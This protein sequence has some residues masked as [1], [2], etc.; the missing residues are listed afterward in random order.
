MNVEQSAVYLALRDKRD[1]ILAQLAPL[2][3]ERDRLRKLVDAADREWRAKAEEIAALE[4]AHD[5]RG[6]CMEL[7]ALARS[8]GAY[9][10][11]ASGG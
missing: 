5:L 8:M 9:S 1:V 6:V 4:R 10:I 7:A 3:V 11:K 2:E